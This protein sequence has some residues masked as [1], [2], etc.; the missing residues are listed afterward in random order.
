[1]K[2]RKMFL[3]L[4]AVV[5]LMGVLLVGTGQALDFEDWSQVWFKLQVQQNTNGTKA[6]IG[7]AIPPGTSSVSKYQDKFKVYLVV[8]SCTAESPA[9]C[10]VTLCS[11]NGTAWGRQPS[12]TWPLLAGNS[13]KFLTLFDFTYTE[14]PLTPITQRFLTPLQVSATVKSSNPHAITGASIQNLG[15]AFLVTVGDPAEQYATGNVQITSTWINPNNVLDDVP[16]ACR[17][18]PGL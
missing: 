10:E 13:E 16:V 11:F 17:V 7:D 3:G 5:G 15:G 1:M 14:N 12:G 18:L 8:E 2:I 4:L 9:A 6:K